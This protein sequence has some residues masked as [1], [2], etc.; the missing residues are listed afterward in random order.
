M[1]KMKWGV[2]ILL[3]LIPLVI[4]RCGDFN[5]SWEIIQF[6]DVVMGVTGL[7]LMPAL[8]ILSFFKKI[9]NACQDLLVMVVMAFYVYVFYMYMLIK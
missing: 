5:S 9:R 4:V 7:F 8:I 3:V 2:F 1:N 6:F